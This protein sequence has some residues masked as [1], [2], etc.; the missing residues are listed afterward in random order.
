[1]KLVMKKWGE[2]ERRAERTIERKNGLTEIKRLWKIETARDR[3]R[4]AELDRYREI[5]SVADRQK[6]GQGQEHG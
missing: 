3:V 4:A 2:A 1:M 6:K 5:G